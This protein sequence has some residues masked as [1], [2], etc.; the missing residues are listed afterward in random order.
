MQETAI[1]NHLHK[2]ITF[3]AITMEMSH[4]QPG[5]NDL[6]EKR[7]GAQHLDSYMGCI[8]AMHWEVMVQGMRGSKRHLIQHASAKA[9]L[10]ARPLT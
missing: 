5:D 3:W 7:A 4:S 9:T 6:A 2:S 8:G 10:T 1:S